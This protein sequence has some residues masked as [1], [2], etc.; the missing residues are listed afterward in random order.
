MAVSM[1]VFLLVRLAT[2]GET[3]SPIS[4][5]ITGRAAQSAKAPS[6]TTS[7]GSEEMCAILAP[8]WT[9]SYVTDVGGEAATAAVLFSVNP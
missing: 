6:I 8:D 5:N 1:S 7:S 9:V 2:E 3:V 4:S